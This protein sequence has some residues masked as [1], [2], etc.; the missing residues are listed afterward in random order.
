MDLTGG[1]FPKLLIGTFAVA[2]LGFVVRGFGQ[3]AVGAGAARLLA[4]PR[5]PVDPVDQVDHL[6]QI[7]HDRQSAASGRL[8]LSSEI[9]LQARLLEAVEAMEEALPPEPDERANLERLRV[10]RPLHRV[11]YTLNGSYHPD[12]SVDLGRLPGLS[13]VEELAAAEIGSHRYEATRRTLV[14]ERNRVHEALSTSLERA[15]RLR[16]RL[17]ADEEGASR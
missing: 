8:D 13:P 4:A 3:L 10:L 16:A 17:V 15:E 9:K 12:P 6:G 7:L 14:R 5:L 11:L 2:V 1:F